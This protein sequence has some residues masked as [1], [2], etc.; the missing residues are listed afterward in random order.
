MFLYQKNNEYIKARFFEYF[1]E[2]D[3]ANHYPTPANKDFLS[4]M[5]GLKWTNVGE[6]TYGVYEQNDLIAKSGQ[7]TVRVESNLTEEFLVYALSPEDAIDRYHEMTATGYPI[8]N[9]T[10]DIKAPKEV[11]VA[12]VCHCSGKVRLTDRQ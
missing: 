7:Y 3:F 4:D 5:C 9:K 8:L 12:D 2:E 10:L 1:N 6:E 11:T